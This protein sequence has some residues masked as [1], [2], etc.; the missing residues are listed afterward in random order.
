MSRKSLPKV[1]SRTV[2]GVVAAGAM[3]VTPSGAVAQEGCETIEAEPPPDPSTFVP[4]PEVGFGG[5]APAESPRQ[6]T[7]LICS[8]RSDAVVSGRT[9]SDTDIKRITLYLLDC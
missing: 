9:Y 7:A 3:V 4:V 5:G 2:F 6:R 8:Q 1:L